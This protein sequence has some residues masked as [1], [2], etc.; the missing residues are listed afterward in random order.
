MALKLEVN[1]GARFGRLRVVQEISRS[2]PGRHFLC[3]CDCGNKTVTTLARMRSGKTRSCGCIRLETTRALG[4]KYG[5]SAQKHGLAGTALYTCHRLMM[6]RC[7]DVSYLR[8][9]SWGGRG[10][11]VCRKWHDLRAFVDW[12]NSLPKEE[13]YRT[14]LTIERRDNARGY[15]PNNCYWATRRQQQR[16]R[17]GN[18]R[19][20]YRGKLSSFMYVY[21][22]L[23]ERKLVPKKSAEKIR[24]RLRQG[25]KLSDIVKGFTGEPKIRWL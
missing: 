14:G 17:R 22:D 15:S 20:M 10:I 3:R 4:K 7:Y 16:N 11:R 19:I 6:K 9:D 12:N 8:Y 1:T 23:I 21:E 13:R 18:V 25:Y 2:S 5:G 24:R